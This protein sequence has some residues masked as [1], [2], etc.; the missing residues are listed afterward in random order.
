MGNVAQWRRP[1]RGEIRSTSIALELCLYFNTKDHDGVTFLDE[2]VERIVTTIRNRRIELTQSQPDTPIDETEL[3]LSV[4]ERDD[5]G[6]TYGLGWTPSGSRRRHAG[7]GGDG[8]GSSRPISAP[9]EPIELLMRDFKEMQ[10]NLLRVMQDNTLT[11]DELREVEGQLRRIEHAL[12]DRLGISFTPPR[13]VLDYSET[14]DDPDD[15]VLTDVYP[16]VFLTWH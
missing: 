9:N 3:Y 5:K 2:R 11:L 16:Y 4:V 14:D 7:A 6:R 12:I 15:W 13:D 1:D 10:T 8:A